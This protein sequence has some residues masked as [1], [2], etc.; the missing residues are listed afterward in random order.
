MARR[1]KPTK[2]NKDKDKAIIINKKHTKKLAN[3]DKNSTTTSTTDNSTKPIK[4]LPSTEQSKQSKNI[5]KLNTEDN[6]SEIKNQQKIL[7][8]KKTPKKD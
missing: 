4:T 6:L 7:V 1:K 5:T 2:T 3:K 8:N